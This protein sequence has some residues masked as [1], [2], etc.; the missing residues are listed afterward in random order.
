[1]IKLVTQAHISN[2]LLR[3]NNIRMVDKK[4][5]Q[6]HLQLSCRAVAMPDKCLI[7]TQGNGADG[8]RMTLHGMELLK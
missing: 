4:R 3:N 2:I 1:M 5:S 7:T 8:C 6:F